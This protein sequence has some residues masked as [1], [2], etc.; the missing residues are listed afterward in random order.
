MAGIALCILWRRG[1]Q[2]GRIWMDH[3]KAALQTWEP[4]AFGEV[5][6][7]RKRPVLSPKPSRLLK[8]ILATV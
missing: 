3:W 8:K 7:Y 2:A 1:I 4:L 6:L 5:N